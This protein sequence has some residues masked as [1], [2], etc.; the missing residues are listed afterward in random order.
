MART[1]RIVT[2]T[3]TESGAVARVE[4]ISYAREDR[5]IHVDN[6]V[7]SSLNPR[8]IK[9]A[10]DE[11]RQAELV[12]SI[13][14]LGVL[15]RLLVRENEEGQIEILAGGSRWRASKIVATEIT[16]RAMVPCTVYGRDLPDDVAFEIAIASNDQRTDPHPLDQCDAFVRLRDK[17]G[18]SVDQIAAR[19]GRSP[20]YVYDRL[21]LEQLTPAGREA[22]IGDKI[23]LGVA[24]ILAR[25]GSTSAQD[26]SLTDL[27]KRFPSGV[28]LEEARHA[29]K[30]RLMVLASA[31]FDTH[32][33][34]LTAAP[35]CDDCPK[36]TDVQKHLFGD[37]LEDTLARC[38]DGDCYEEKRTSSWSQH[39]ARARA[40]GKRVA[41]EDEQKKIAPNAW[42]GLGAGYE[43]LDDHHSLGEDKT[44]REALGKKLKGVEITVVRDVNGAPIDV[45]KRSEL[46][47]AL[48][49]KAAPK[50]A[51]KN[52]VDHEL[53]AEIERAAG[54]LMLGAIASKSALAKN[55]TA[56]FWRAAAI[57]AVRV[58]D[59]ME[60]GDAIL[61]IVER[62]T[63]V[64]Y[65]AGSEHQG[66][67]AS[68]VLVELVG[69]M[70]PG[71]A[72]SLV[73][74]L[75]V[76]LSPNIASPPIAAALSI[77]T[78]ALRRD[79]AKAVR[80][81]RKAEEREARKSKQKL[82]PKLRK[83]LKAK[84]AEGDEDAARALE[85]TR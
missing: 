5:E 27:V 84:A 23:T 34:K 42:G 62:R 17:H 69:K 58:V 12:E 77:D 83:Q 52:T 64:G 44:W 55:A 8:T 38:T 85:E 19:V 33:A 45:A 3:E 2:Q 78:K 61:P 56:K 30:L 73:V 24:L 66:K 40:E 57:A 76:S 28:P 63:F 82:S 37:L 4:A 46:E 29:A 36:R 67:T 20:Q 79:A 75:L 9:T 32:D 60:A 74:E 35:A 10:D 39:E 59:D 70:S 31:P 6:L 53:E 81:K 25:I 16:S 80:A 11:R 54:G 1:K 47:A 14:R 26:R 48:D 65:A 22:L 51:T 50:P 68:E 43:R 15:D 71:Q 7:E 13:R 21:R 49:P 41:D 72:W 18:R